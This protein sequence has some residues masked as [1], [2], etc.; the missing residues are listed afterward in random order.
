MKLT[1]SSVAAL[2]LPEG[3]TDHIEWDTSLPG[4]GIR[5]RGQGKHYVIQYRC[6]VRQHRESLGNIFKI[7]L[8]QAR[9]IARQRFAQVELGNDP[10]AEKAK[11]R[12]A[13]AVRALTLNVAA[14]RY[15]DY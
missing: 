4:F 8:D 11:V 9:S 12:A 13:S 7:T 6:G 10:A 2:A 15:L 1:G 3:K 5:V 14:E